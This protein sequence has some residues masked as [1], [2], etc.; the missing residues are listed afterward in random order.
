MIAKFF[1]DRPVLANVI[2][3]IIVLIGAVAVFGLPVSQYPQLTPPT[4]QVTT[5]FPGAS[6]LT[7]QQQVAQT[8]EQ[9]V[10][11]VENM[12]YMQS[13]SSNDGRYTLTVSFAVGTDADQAQVAVQNRVAAAVPL[14]PN[15]V[16]Q[17][18]VVTKKKSTNILQIVTLS[19]ERPE[20]DALLLSNF[21]SLKLKDRLVRLPG[22]A[23]VS[24][25]GVGQYSMR[26]WL[27][28]Q[29]MKQRGLTP[30]NVIAQ[31]NKQSQPISVGQIGAPPAP[32]GQ[33][34][35]LT[36]NLSGAPNTAEEFGSII[37]KT[38]SSGAVTRL[39][40]VARI[41]LGSQTYGQ[42][43]SL[44]G[45]PAAG[46]AIYQLPDANALAT[47][48]AVKTETARLA[49]DFPPG[50]HYDVP[51]DTTVF[52]K[53]SIDEVYQTLYEAGILVLLVIIVFL[54]DW[55]ATL[56]PA[57][58]V[59]ITVIGAFAAM[60]ALGF[61]INL[62]TLF[63]LVLCIGIV[64][65]DAIVVVEGVAKYVEAGKTPREAAITAMQELLG[66]II[67]I[68]L[69]L[70]SVFLPAAFIP[71]ITGQMYR[72]FALVIAA[73][74]L[75]SGINAITLK[76]TQSVKYVRPHDPAKQKNAFYR[77]FD[78]LYFPLEA[79]YA[80]LIERL[81]A[82][83]KISALVA[84]A[85]IV[86]AIVG[87]ALLPTGFIPTEDQGYLLVAVQLPDAASIQRT[88]K[89]LGEVD[90]IARALPGVEHVITIGGISPL[91][92]NASLANA[93]LVYLTLKDWDERAKQKG[94]D[95]RSLYAELNRRL[96]TVPEIQPLVL[97]P[98]PIPGLG[99]SGGFQ[100]QLELTD[101]SG[102]LNKL[103]AAAQR[104]IVTAKMRPE[105][106]AVFTP[107]RTQV[108][109]LQ[110]TLNRARAE[111]L[112]VAVNDV[113]DVLQS[114]LGSAYVG[115]FSKFGQ[116]YTI[117]VQADQSFR[118]RADQI[119]AL[120]V[121]NK[122][123]DMVPVGSFLTAQPVTGPAL[124]SQ[125]QMYP[126]AT[127]NGM[128]APGYS[129]G[130]AL[131][132]MEEAAAEVLP[133]GIG[134]EWTAL[135]YQEKLVGSSVTLVFGLAILLVYLVLA[136]Q[137][138]NWWLPIPVILAVPMSLVGTVSVLWAVGLANNI[139]VQ[140]GLVLLI[141]LSAKNAILIVEVAQEIRHEGHD[142]V[143][144]A[145][146]GSRRRF[147]PILMTSFAFILGVVPLVLAKGAGAAARVS[148]GLTVFSGMLASTLLAVAFVPVLYVVIM[149]WRERRTAG[150]HE[151]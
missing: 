24:V 112:G 37:L 26:V 90:R 84:L 63:A 97:V 60:A 67:G 34:Q 126:T 103:A 87:L 50:L 124:V 56:V 140:I 45:R 119:A 144:A 91:D 133:Q 65:D 95:L 4:V 83:R 54:Q 104:L 13:T 75:I 52:V 42:T 138:E 27:D 39:R 32:A 61:S 43:F 46:V 51:F 41:E 77:A 102:D 74:A 1:I 142:I 47:S 116:N 71:G 118:S 137:Y 81:M 98:P 3:W 105:I 100:M 89:A 125:Y 139:Y 107:L 44:D 129:S 11:G 131:A 58:T 38:D 127:L 147:R 21:A 96:A 69:V 7:V 92:G 117:Y 132:A 108:P 14:L 128:A 73:T 146:E 145:L 80:R 23:D 111:M 66:P 15:A 36:V 10:N 59:P 136:G 148:I 106:Q 5:R 134:Y 149:S 9:Q 114:Y 109:Q 19:S 99:M 86:L 115:Q 22:V 72:Q 49:R 62:L 120:T 30:A 16:Q 64:V 2:A 130:Q 121:R 35:Q 31:L 79:R 12:L 33:A 143:H 78:R 70:M 57:T 88:E 18:G 82:A 29:Q 110:L 53:T 48:L 123:G 85:L 40:D 68:T 94:Q 141:A 101:G 113:Y 135:S 122:N 28:P 55:R 6:A 20:M 93:G 150:K 76:P 8:I 25:F 17:Q 151:T